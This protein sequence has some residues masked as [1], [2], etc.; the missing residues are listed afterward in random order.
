MDPEPTHHPVL[1]AHIYRTQTREHLFNCPNWKAQ[2][3]TLCAEVRRETR[4]AKDRFKIRDLFA[5]ERRSLAILDGGGE[6]GPSP[7]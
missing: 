1:V 3:K 2:Q 7:G 5:D 6:A 4:R